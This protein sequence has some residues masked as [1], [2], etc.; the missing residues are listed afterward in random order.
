MIKKCFLS[1]KK[2]N[3]KYKGFTLI[4]LLIVIAII[5]LLASIVLVSFPKA[6]KGARDVVRKSDMKQLQKAIEVYRQSNSSYPVTGWSWWGVSVN[7]GSRSTSGSNAYIPGLTPDY[8]GVLPIDPLK[9]S[10]GWSGYIYLSP[11]GTCYKLLDHVN[12]PESFPSAGEP[13]YDPVRPGWAWM[14]CSPDPACLYAC[15]G[16]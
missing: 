13:F 6:M 7:G 4:E 15:N 14:V 8:A 16:W 10:S 3:F 2:V 11:D 12:G 9:D 5:G 1:N